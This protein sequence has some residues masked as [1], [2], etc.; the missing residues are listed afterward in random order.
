MSDR[1]MTRA[2]NNM[3]VKITT[4]NIF[5][6]TPM[7]SS[8]IAHWAPSQG[9]EEFAKIFRSIKVVREKP[10]G[11]YLIPIFKGEARDG[12]WSNAMIYKAYRDCRG[13]MMDS[14]GTG[15]T[16]S[17]TAEKIKKA[18]SKNRLKCKWI[19]VRCQAQQEVECGPRTVWGMVSI[20]QAIKDG[21]SI[22]EIIA[23]AT[24]RNS[25]AMYDPDAIRRKVVTLVDE[26]TE[27]RERTKADS[28]IWRRFWS[29]RRREGENS[30]N[31]RNRNAEVETIEID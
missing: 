5:I 30:R 14:L 16:T 17:E 10:N 19:P 21:L 11:Y 25:E 20:C 31:T 26:T 13:W 3:R 18:F 1:T 9:W 27:V 6:A 29:R 23:T 28:V 4:S 15:G 8:I 24:L 2:V 22:E 12:H 7:A